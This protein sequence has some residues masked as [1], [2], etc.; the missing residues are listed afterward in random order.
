M[1]SERPYRRA[2]TVDQAAQILTDGRGRQWDLQVVDAFLRSIQD[3]CPYPLPTIVPPVDGATSTSGA[4]S[5]SPSIAAS[6]GVTA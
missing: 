5:P 2:L 6:D 1:T 4:P 3:R